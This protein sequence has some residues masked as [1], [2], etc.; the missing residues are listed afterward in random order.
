MEKAGDKVWMR[1]KSQGH[2]KVSLA[3]EPGKIRAMQIIES[4]GCWRTR[5]MLSKWSFKY[6]IIFKMSYT[7]LTLKILVIIFSFLGN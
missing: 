5:L 3:R 1:E 6:G 2:F 4:L 7:E